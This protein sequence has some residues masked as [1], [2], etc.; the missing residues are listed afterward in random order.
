M[1][2]RFPASQLAWLSPV[3]ET[4]LVVSGTATYPPPLNRKAVK[5][6]IFDRV[7][8]G[9]LG[10]DDDD[11]LLK[12]LD[13]NGV[14]SIAD[15]FS[16]SDSQ[17]DTLSLD[18]GTIVKLI[19]LASRNKLRILRSWN[20]HLRQG[21]RSVDWMDATIVNQDAWEEYCVALYVPVEPSNKAPTPRPRRPVNRAVPPSHSI[22]VTAPAPV[23]DSP[24]APD[25]FLSDEPSDLIRLDHDVENK[26]IVDGEPN[27][28]IV[29]GE[30]ESSA[31]DIFPD[32]FRDVGNVFDDADSVSKLV[33]NVLELTGPTKASRSLAFDEHV[34][35]LVDCCGSRATTRSIGNVIDPVDF[36]GDDN[37]LVDWCVFGQVATS[38]VVFDPGG[39]DRDVSFHISA[40]SPSEASSSSVFLI[41]CFWIAGNSKMKGFTLIC[42]WSVLDDPSQPISGM[43][44]PRSLSVCMAVQVCDSGY[45]TTVSRS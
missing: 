20:F 17:I 7:L 14:E 10:F 42:T 37:D 39:G 16:L 34:V 43:R 36:G 41:C 44:S 22:Q 30:P 45:C 40:F 3:I 1:I 15:V 33:L 24:T 29:H 28:S 9:V 12:A 11:L 27:M 21:G 5:K 2:D 19:P 38:R 26:S 6:A 8:K 25:P 13:G 32:A 4:M 31:A 18:Q 23:V 35:L